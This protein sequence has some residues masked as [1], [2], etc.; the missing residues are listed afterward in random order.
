MLDLDLAAENTNK[1]DNYKKAYIDMGPK[2]YGKFV[3]GLWGPPY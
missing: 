2:G 1:L 3:R